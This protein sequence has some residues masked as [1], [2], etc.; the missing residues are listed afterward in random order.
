MKIAASGK[1][2]P[3]GTSDHDNKAWFEHDDDAAW[4]SFSSKF[5][6][7]GSSIASIE[8]SNIGDKVTDLIVP[9][10][11]QA[12]PGYIRKLQGELEMAPGSLAQEVWNESE[13]PYVN[14]EIERTATVQ[15]GDS[16]SD[17]EIAFQQAR[18]IHT[19][20]ALARYLD[21]PESEID[22]R[23]VPTIAMCGSGGG[24][25]ALVAG[26]SSYLSAQ[27]AHLFDCVTY[28]AGVSGS[29]W[30]QS[31]YYS[32]LSRQNHQAII[33]HLKKRINIHIALPPPA[34]RL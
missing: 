14:P 1:S 9:G 21:I 34:L 31:L 4:Q 25:R 27:E 19:A 5:S 18:K 28:T 11:A 13:D 20:R 10:W 17:E 30:L 2:L 6:E 3:S 23:D 33:N 26:T 8:W 7:I 12:L 29:C 22:P 24:L 16:L 15:I 32:S